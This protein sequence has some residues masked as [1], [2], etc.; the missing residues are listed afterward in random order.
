M[1][2]SII[3]RNTISV[4]VFTVLSIIIYDKIANMF[5][6]DDIN[7]VRIENYYKE[8]KDSID[9]IFLG[10]SHV[11]NTIQPYQLFHDYGITSSLLSSSSQS[12]P[13]SY[14]LLKDA[15]KYQHPKAVVIDSYY[16]TRNVYAVSQARVRIITDGMPMYS[17]NRVEMINDISTKCEKGSDAPWT[18]YFKLGYHHDKWEEFPW[19]EIESNIKTIQATKGYNFHKE[20]EKFE[21][22]ISKDKPTPIPDIPKEY[23]D[24]IMELCKEKGI[25]LV[26]ISIPY[27]A[28][29]DHKDQ[30]L[31][32][33][34]V[35]PSITEYAHNN[36]ISYLN[37]MEVD[38]EIGINYDTDFRDWQHLNYYGSK[39]VN[40]Y[41]GKYLLEEV[42]IENH[43]KDD[44]YDEWRRGWY[45]FREY[46]ENEMKSTTDTSVVK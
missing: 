20:V 11:H 25:R 2:C 22:I 13:C 28:D 32:E 33:T 45:S 4:I 35:L 10:S 17:T 5:C 44:Q 19:K 27:T 18:F 26:V 37:L 38:D 9:V 15:L 7:V 29:D 1:K 42:G 31:E 41:I 3:I 24:R 39:K 16:I 8:P 40:S 46:I 23:L 43:R 30:V 12:L 6:E 14:F 36:N 34:S 21:R